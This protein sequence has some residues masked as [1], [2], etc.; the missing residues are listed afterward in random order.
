MV[1]QEDDI[2]LGGAVYNQGRKGDWGDVILS[3]KFVTDVTP[4]DRRSPKLGL[5]VP[6]ALPYHSAR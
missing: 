6:W 4:G 2:L 1:G 3:L 5:C